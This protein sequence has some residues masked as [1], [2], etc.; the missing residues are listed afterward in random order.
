[1]SD[2]RETDVISRLILSR[3]DGVEEGLR[4]LN[5]QVGGR[6]AGF[7]RLHENVLELEGFAADPDMPEETQ[8]EFAAATSSVPLT[9]LGL[10]IVNA[11][12][13]KEPVYA[14]A[15]PVD[16]KLVDSA[17]W[18]VRFGAKMSLSCP[19]V[20][21]DGNL[22]GVLAVSFTNEHDDISEEIERL[23]DLAAKLGEESVHR[24]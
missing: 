24:M 5:I 16:G 19:V 13:K 6:A 3:E 23:K 8:A 12:V 10:G 11:A 15:E 9:E 7:W 4:L 14:F 2:P 17:S 1:M 22:W 20:N 21:P 18:I